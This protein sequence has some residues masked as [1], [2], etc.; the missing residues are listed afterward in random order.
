MRGAFILITMLVTLVAT[1]VMAGSVSAAGYFT[2]ITPR[3][4][5]SPIVHYR[6]RFDVYDAANYCIRDE[7][8]F[9][10][11]F[12]CESYDTNEAKIDVRLFRLRAHSLR[13]VDQETIFGMNGKASEDVYS[14]QL[15][16]PY[17]APPGTRIPFRAIFRL[18][19][20]VTDRIVAKK[21]RSFAVYY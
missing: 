20:P 3:F 8:G 11:D 2:S 13:F 6:I 5:R 1:L 16:T 17:Y 10:E 21:S 18:I 19:D 4:G 7:W 14:Y 12:D 9:Y 15:R